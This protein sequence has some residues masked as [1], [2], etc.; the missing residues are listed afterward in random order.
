VN[1]VKKTDTSL[2]VLV[3]HDL[4]C[5][6]DQFFELLSA[7]EL[8]KREVFI[9]FKVQSVLSLCLNQ[10]LDEI[11]FPNEVNHTNLHKWLDLDHEDEREGFCEVFLLVATLK[12]KS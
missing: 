12:C 3:S 2:G 4:N 10:H 5:A 1:L 9:N 11:V 8:T 7:D 6:P